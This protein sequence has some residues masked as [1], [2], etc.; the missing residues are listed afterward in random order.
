MTKRDIPRL[1]RHRDFDLAHML[2]EMHNAVRLRKGLRA[3]P[4]AIHRRGFK[5]KY[6][7]L[8]YYLGALNATKLPMILGGKAWR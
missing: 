6:K 8:P 7:E 2:M 4:P 5:G 1:R 3:T